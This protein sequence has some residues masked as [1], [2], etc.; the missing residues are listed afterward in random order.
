MK[1]FMV[2]W[3]GEL[4]SMIG[5]GMTAFAVAVYVYQL[6]GSAAAVS[7]ATLCAY[8]PAI[9]FNPIGG[10]LADR[11]DRRLMMILG[12]SLSI[13]GLLIILISIQTGIVGIFPILIG[14]AINS[15][16][17]GLLEPAYKATITDLLTEEQYAKGSALLQMAGASKYLISPFV[18]G[19][20]LSIADIR[21]ILIL[22]IATIFI[23]VITIQ[24]VRKNI[25]YVKPI[26]KQRHFLHEIKEGF[27]VLSFNK[28]VSQLIFLMA[29]VCFFV[30]IIQTMIAPMILAFANAKTLGTIES[31][32]AVGML[33]G[34]IIISSVKMKGGYVKTLIL[35]FM[36]TGLFM[37]LVGTTTNV[38][39]LIGYCFMFF[40]TLPFINT[41]ADVLLRMNI[42]NDV[43]GR[44]WGMISILTQAGYVVAYSISGLLAEFLF[45]PLLG[46]EGVLASTV[47]QWIGTGQGRGIAFML[48]ITG[49]TMVI[50]ACLFGFKKTIKKMGSMSDEVVTR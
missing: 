6:S 50:C 48:I 1:K 16:F 10:V 19:L 39:L 25:P 45:E 12:D 23:T 31:V 17:I 21:L 14:V 3:A 49:L 42:P 27:K 46:K 41:C 24:L 15:I 28:T 26:K 40:L 37:A 43:Q 7:L 34:S 20:L 2:I 9:L 36:T 38:L 33:I 29:C 44:A 22:D 32:S 4:I 35:S 30:G 5:S 47:G 11:Y 13:I 8:L 18:A